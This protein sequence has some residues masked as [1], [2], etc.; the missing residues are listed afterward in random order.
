MNNL[1]CAEETPIPN[2]NGAEEDGNSEKEVSGSQDQMKKMVMR[3]TC[4]MRVAWVGMS[5]MAALVPELE[6][7]LGSHSS[8]PGSKTC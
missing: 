5:R 4:G 2:L 6:F 8:E 7:Q 1:N 3:G